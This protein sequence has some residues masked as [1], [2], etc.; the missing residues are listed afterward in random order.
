MLAWVSNN[1][2]VENQEETISPP[3]ELDGCLGIMMMPGLDEREVGN[4]NKAVGILG[5]TSIRKSRDL[6]IEITI[7]PL[8]GWDG[9]HHRP[10]KL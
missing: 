5:P 7:E 10:R 2:D 6:L 1:N 3:R 4:K 9:T 8:T